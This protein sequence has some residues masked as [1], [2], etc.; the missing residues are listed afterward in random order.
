MSGRR[1]SSDRE[2]ERDIER[3]RD[4][5]YR[6]HRKRAARFRTIVVRIIASL[7]AVSFLATLVISSL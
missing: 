6:A 1:R 3:A 4:E 2:R 7:V 5:E